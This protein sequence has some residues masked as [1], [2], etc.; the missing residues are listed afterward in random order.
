MAQTVWSLPPVCSRQAEVVWVRTGPS[1]TASFLLRRLH[2]CGQLPGRGG[3]AMTRRTVGVGWG[4]PAPR[5][6]GYAAGT[7]AGLQTASSIHA[8][9]AS[10]HSTENPPFVSSRFSIVESSLHQHRNKTTSAHPSGAV[11]G[12][13][14]PP[15]EEWFAE[16]SGPGIPPENGPFSR[17][18]QR[19]NDFVGCASC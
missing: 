12:R 15:R 1:L 3:P 13:T 5:A 9:F 16:M 18:D 11:F 6:P 19:V 2:S 7:S 4:R 17:S 10:N 8:L 14:A